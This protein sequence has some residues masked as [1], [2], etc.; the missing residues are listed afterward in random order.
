MF[1]PESMQ[2]SPEPL[3]GLPGPEPG[4]S[5][6]KRV[7][8]WAQREAPYLLALGGLVFVLVIRH[9]VVGPSSPKTKP[10]EVVAAKAADD[11]DE[12][13]LSFLLRV[14][15]LSVVNPEGAILLYT[16]SVV[17]G[18]LFAVGCGV[19]MWWLVSLL[20]GYAMPR[21]AGAWVERRWSLWDVVKVIGMYFFLCM[22]TL[23]LCEV[24]QQVGPLKAWLRDLPPTQE[25]LLIQFPASVLICALIAYVVCIEKGHQLAE[26][27]FIPELKPMLIG[28]LGY[29]G[30][31]PV[32]AVSAIVC[33]WVVEALGQTPQGHP[34]ASEFLGPQPVWAVVAIAVFACLLAPLWEELFFRGILYPVVRRLL[35]A[36]LSIAVTALA[37]AAVHANLSQLA[38]LF[39]LG[40]LLAYLYERTHSLWSCI[41]AHAVFNS[42]SI[43]ALLVVRYSLRGLEL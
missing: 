15:K 9:V 23:A 27:G 25:G 43:T 1:E 16:L 28:L 3:G 26:L 10:A 20:I 5:L 19:L 34:I 2:Q 13:A 39:V 24:L 6:G 21:S 31:L 41:A 14:W 22:T 35:G 36:P 33:F 29:L 37:F 30:A 32:V 17:I 8:R 42:V 18:G 40:V 38:P 12:S 7:L 4:K 11:G